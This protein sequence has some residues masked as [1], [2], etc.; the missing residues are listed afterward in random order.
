MKDKIRSA[1]L[2]ALAQAQAEGLLPQVTAPAFA[3]EKPKQAEHGDLALNLAMVLA[4]PCRMNPRAV[5]Q[6][7]IER[8]A[9][10][11]GLIERAEIAG[12]G[13]INLFCR[14]LAWLSVAPEVLAQ[15]DDFGRCALG[16]GRR[17]QVEF[18]S[19]NPTGPLHVGHGRGAALGDVMARLLAFAGW[20][21]A[22]EYYINDAGNQMATLGRSVLIRARQA[23]GSDEPFP[24]KHYRGDYIVDLAEELLASPEGAGLLAMPQDQAVDL[25]TD[26]AGGK[27][28]AGIKD[29]LAVFGVNIATYFSERSL[30]ADGK[31]Q[32]ALDELAARGLLYEADGALWFRSSQFGDDKDRVVRRSNGELTYFASDIAYHLD[33]FKRGFDAVVDIWG[34]DHHGYVP[35]LRAAVRAAG[36]QP[37]DL[38]VVLV[39]MVNLLRGGN[40]V[41]MSTRAGEF[42]TLREVVDEVG[43]D[44]ARFIF[45]TRR[46]DAPLD[47]DL[48][49][50]KQ[51]SMDNP[52]F[53]VQYAHTRVCSVLRKALEAGQGQAPP[54]GLDLGRLGP[55]EVDLAK[56]IGQ[57]PEMVRGAAETLEPHRVAYYLRELASAFHSYYNETHI[58][59]DDA[60][61]SA[62]R[63]CLARAVGQVLRNGLALLGVS[64][65]E[66]M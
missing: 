38:T 19:A 13:F 5:A 34:A 45:L 22:T 59:V 32:A 27:I 58:L 65:P 56:I 42:V 50:A 17:A 7:I 11:G 20:E 64:A 9:D 4:K 6:I 8:M 46:S 31:V 33:K 21:V 18:V 39:Q 62:A 36:R 66:A 25:A 54:Q 29:D 1:A 53:Y 16:A 49:V 3:V 15:G 48:D 47:F 40:P 2:A 63:L 43:A 51:K 41:A 10:A 60:A 28:L 14:P 30:F 52:V 37:E 61:L 35:R 55:A 57:F 12:P 24:D 44:S 26:W 23:R